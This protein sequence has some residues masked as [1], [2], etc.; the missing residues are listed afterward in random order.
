M[1]CIIVPIIV[2]IS[3]TANEVWLFFDFLKMAAAAIFDF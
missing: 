2:K 1:K 3:Q